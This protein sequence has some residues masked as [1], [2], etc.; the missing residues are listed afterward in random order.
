MSIEP[1]VTVD[2]GWF[3]VRRPGINIIY[4]D[5]RMS[6]ESFARFYA[7]LVDDLESARGTTRAVLYDVPDSGSMTASR[8]G[9]VA[10]LLKEYEGVLREVTTGYALV[11][12]SRFARGVLTAIFWVAPPPYPNKIC[13]TVED[14]FEWLGPLTPGLDAGSVL[15]WYMAE[16]RRILVQMERL[17]G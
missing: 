11:S 2:A 4:V 10:D 16:R 6:D 5:E 13:A 1:K 8:R 7:E 15:R 17:A 12:P 3:S 14:A 9:K